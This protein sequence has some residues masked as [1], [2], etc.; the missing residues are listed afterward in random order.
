MSGHHPFFNGIELRFFNGLFVSLR[1]CEVA[2]LMVFLV[3]AVGPA[4]SRFTFIGSLGL[5]AA[6]AAHRLLHSWVTEH[7][8]GR[9]KR[10]FEKRKD[11]SQIRAIL[12]SSGPIF[13]SGTLGRRVFDVLL[14][15]LVVV[16]LLILLS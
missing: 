13:F 7:R 14:A 2:A 16:S 3:A 10:I 5:L 8:L 1:F 4:D 11:L 9:W 15:V 6:Y 12:R